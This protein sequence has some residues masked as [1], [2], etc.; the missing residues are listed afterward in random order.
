[1]LNDDA[2]TVCGDQ[3]KEEEEELDAGQ[4]HSAVPRM[5]S[6]AH[7]VQEAAE[8]AC[9]EA[10]G[11]HDDVGSLVLPEEANHYRQ[12]LE[13]QNEYRGVHGPSIPADNASAVALSGKVQ[14]AADN[15]YRRRVLAWPREGVTAEDEQ[16]R[17]STFVSAR[18]CRCPSRYSAA[19]ATCHTRSSWHRCF[20][21]HRVDHSAALILATA[22]VEDGVRHQEPLGQGWQSSL[23]RA[24]SAP[25]PGGDLVSAAPIA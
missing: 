10:V 12:D 11:H 22:V 20:F 8:G 15:P 14:L 7:P 9:E 21:H 5:D 6:S 24:C 25:H 18:S 2:S 23:S 19:P 1:M 16:S 4:Y 13:Q 3:K 17:S